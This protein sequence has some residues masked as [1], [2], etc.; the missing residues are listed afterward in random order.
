MQSFVWL[1]VLDVSAI[2]TFYIHTEWFLRQIHLRFLAIKTLKAF[3]KVFTKVFKHF[4]VFFR[5]RYQVCL[6]FIY[7]WRHAFEL[8]HV[9]SWQLLLKGLQLTL[10]NVD[11]VADPG[12]RVWT[13]WM[14]KNCSFQNS[15]FSWFVVDFILRSF[16]FTHIEIVILTTNKCFLHRA[17]LFLL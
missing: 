11:C 7:K 2:N 6:S 8:H 3:W 10:K 13:Y 12:V 17:L 15:M 9:V 14:R 1:Q 16:L 4:H 5:V